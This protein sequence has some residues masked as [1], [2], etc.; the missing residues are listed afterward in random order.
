MMFLSESAITNKSCFFPAKGNIAI[1]LRWDHGVSWLLVGAQ[2]PGI[3]RQTA[4]STD[5]PWRILFYGTPQSWLSSGQD[6]PN[7]LFCGLY[8]V[9]ESPC[10]YTLLKSYIDQKSNGWTQYRISMPAIFFSLLHCRFLASDCSSSDWIIT[11]ES[12]FYSH[13]IK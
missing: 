1:T 5:Q 4:N 9:Q 6:S 11:D 13:Q 8:F 10:I 7:F 3:C 2:H 12:F